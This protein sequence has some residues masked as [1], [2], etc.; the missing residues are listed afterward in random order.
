[1]ITDNNKQISRFFFLEKADNG[2]YK[3][4]GKH[5]KT[6]PP[7]FITLSLGKRTIIGTMMLIASFLVENYAP[8]DSLLVANPYIYHPVMGLLILGGL[9]LI[10]L[11]SIAYRKL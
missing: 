11:D 3:I 6:K 10:F 8:D 7:K 4:F 2:G 9:L 1:M 5:Y